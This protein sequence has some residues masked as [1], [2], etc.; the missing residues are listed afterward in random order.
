MA[1]WEATEQLHMS[2]MRVDIL[3]T[4]RVSHSDR[5]ASVTTQTELVV[6]TCMPEHVQPSKWGKKDVGEG[7]PSLFP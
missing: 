5:F 6:M 1:G 2:D 3:E 4:L 7:N